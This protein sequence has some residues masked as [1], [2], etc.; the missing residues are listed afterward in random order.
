MRI[1]SRIGATAAMATVAVATILT[2]PAH[3]VTVAPKA[4]DSVRTEAVAADDVSVARTKYWCGSLDYW[5]CVSRRNEFNRYYTVSDIYRTY[6][7][8][9]PGGCGDSYYFYYW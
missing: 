4:A 6:G 2:G 7:R 8:T 3:A 9:C 1:R 5:Y